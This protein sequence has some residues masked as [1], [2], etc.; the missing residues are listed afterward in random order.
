MV[1]STVNCGLEFLTQ[2]GEMFKPLLI[3]EVL[4]DG[5]F[6]CHNVP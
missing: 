3:G 1:P 2:F 5:V 6:Q 4:L